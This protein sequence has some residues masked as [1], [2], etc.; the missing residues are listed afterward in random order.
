MKILVDTSK[1]AELSINSFIRLIARIPS[2]N[3]ATQLAVS[4]RFFI[5]CIPRSKR[6][7]PSELTLLALILHL[8]TGNALLWTTTR[9]FCAY[10]LRT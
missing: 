8:K 2:Y 9:D 1:A 7:I 3:G 4:S 5:L 6:T 10:F